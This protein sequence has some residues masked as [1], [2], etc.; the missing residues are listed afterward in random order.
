MELKSLGIRKCASYEKEQGF[1]GTLEISSPTSEV[2]IQL[3]DDA[4]RKIL[5]IAGEGIK[6]AARNTA[7]FLV[8]QA[9][10][11]AAGKVL[12]ISND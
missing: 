9:T 10:L 3:T 12:E 1:T 8:S 7:D 6:D 11:V 2:K 4:C 5:V